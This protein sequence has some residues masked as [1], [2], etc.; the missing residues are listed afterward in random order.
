[1]EKLYNKKAYYMNN[2]VYTTQKYYKLFN[3]FLFASGFTNYFNF[4]N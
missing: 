3:L 4:Y 1:M 2:P